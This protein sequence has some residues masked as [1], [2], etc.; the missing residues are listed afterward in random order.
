[1]DEPMSPPTP[2]ILGPPDKGYIDILDEAMIAKKKKEQE[3]PRK[4]NPLRPSAAGFCARKLAYDFNEYRGKAKYEQEE[5]SPDLQ[6]LFNLG[7]SI[8]YALIKDFKAVEA[9]QVKYL[10]QALTFTRISETE[11]IEGSN[12]IVIYCGEHRAIGDAKSKGVKFSS[13][14]E[15]S[16][17]ETDDKFRSMK[18]LVAINSRVYYADDLEVFLNELDDDL[19][20]QNFLQ[21]NGYACTE[22]MKER[23]VDHCFILQYQKN[24]SKL[25]EI[26]FR[27]SQK[28]ADYVTEKFRKVAQAIDSDAG[29]ETIEREFSLGSASCAF[30]R[31]KERCYPDANAKKEYFATWPDKDWPKDTSRLGDV[32][33][34]L[35]ELYSVY[36]EADA[37]AGRQKNV[38]EG[39]CNI[40]HE[41]QIR[42]V[43]FA[44]GRV[45]ELR[46]LKSPRPHFELRPGKL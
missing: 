33:E 23:G 7:H 19:F 2:K 43:R 35:E 8:E 26:R 15:S 10:Q 28:L 25:R 29:P 4:Y 45:Y 21:L 6:R 44:D 42:K 30:C 22:F 13:Y 38:E 41:R 36:A 14:R 34:A 9:F 5:I 17:E 37:A 40:L 32:G 24:K 31:H 39:L 27:P 11:L 12:D 3:G 20:A 16:W 46:F 1:M 18:S